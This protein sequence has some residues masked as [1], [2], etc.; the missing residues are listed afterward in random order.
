MKCWICKSEMINTVGDNYRCPNCD[1]AINDIVCR[2][3]SF[4]STVFQEDI[5]P[6]K[7]GWICPK[8]GRVYAPGTVMCSFC[9][10]DSYTV[11]TTTTGTIG[12]SIADIDIRDNTITNETISGVNTE[13][14]KPFK[15]AGMRAKYQEWIGDTEKLNEEFKKSIKG[16][17]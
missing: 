12:G 2:G 11:T 15:E 6:Y 1:F 8:C 4:N 10:N 17:K 14:N 3:N 5:V 13:T 7:Y 16:V 9:G